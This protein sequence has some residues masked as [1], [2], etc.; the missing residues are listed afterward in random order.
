MTNANGVREHPGGAQLSQMETEME[1]DERG[2]V[3]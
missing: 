2:N 1:G 3:V